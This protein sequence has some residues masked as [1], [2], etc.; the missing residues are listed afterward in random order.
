MK[1]ML[2]NSS[3]DNSIYIDCEEKIVA[4]SIDEVID[5]SYEFSKKIKDAVKS[6]YP[7]FLKT[8]YPTKYINSTN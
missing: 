4:K 8:L 3:R 7:E 1:V 5:K 2:K 6:A